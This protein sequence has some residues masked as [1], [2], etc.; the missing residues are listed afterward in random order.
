MSLMLQCKDPV[1]SLQRTDKAVGL[2]RCRVMH[3]HKNKRV[4]TELKTGRDVPTQ[5]DSP[6]TGCKGSLSLG[7]EVFQ[8]QGQFSFGQV[9]G[10]TTV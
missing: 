10:Q 2:A 7:E 5:G 1:P 8:A 4:L 9:W 6:S 3:M